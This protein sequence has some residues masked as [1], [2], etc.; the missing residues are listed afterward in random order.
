MDG[1]LLV[2]FA[3]AFAFVIALMFLLSWVLKRVGLASSFLP[4]N[5]AARRLKVVEFLP[6]DHQHKLV[7]VSCDD[8]E[9]LL[10]LGRQG[11]V[12]VETNIPAGSR[13]IVEISRGQKNVQA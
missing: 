10:L 11:E 4:K 5:S 2:K 12:V 1:M 13:N 8:R 7:L 9:H 6:V 3:S